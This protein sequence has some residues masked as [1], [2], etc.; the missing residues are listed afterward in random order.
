MDSIKLNLYSKEVFVFTPKGDVKIL[1]KGAS[2]LDYAFSV[3]SD[4]GMKCVGAKVNGRLVPIS[5]IL[6]NGDQVDILS[7]ANQK[8]EGQ[9]AGFFGDI[10]SEDENQTILKF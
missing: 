5:Y 6:E 2:A 8:T 10:K 1:P 3:H 9:L 7:S 4:L